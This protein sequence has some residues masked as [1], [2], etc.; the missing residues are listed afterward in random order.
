MYKIPFLHPPSFSGQG[1]YKETRVPLYPQLM[2]SMGPGLVICT[3]RPACVIQVLD[4]ADERWG[5]GS[6]RIQQL[7]PCL[8]SH[9]GFFVSPSK[10]YPLNRWTQRVRSKKKILYEYLILYAFSSQSNQWF[11]I[12]SHHSL[13]PHMILYPPSLSVD[14]TLIILTR[15]YEVH[16]DTTAYRYSNQVLHNVLN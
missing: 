9:L 7:T 15:T 13:V 4:A 1:K 16:L 3:C 8:F 10:G 11:L 2:P 5:E 12:A 14:C 6:S